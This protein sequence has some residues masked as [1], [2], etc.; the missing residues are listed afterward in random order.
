MKKRIVIASILGLVMMLS[1]LAP[2]VLA[3]PS[4][5]ATVKMGQENGTGSGIRNHDQS[6]HAK[7]KLVPRTVVISAGGSVTYNFTGYHKIAIFA[8]G[9]QPGDVTN[10]DGTIDDS[11]MIDGTPNTDSWTTSAGTFDTPG[12]YLVICNFAPHFVNYDMYGW[13]IVQ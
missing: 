1:A 10:P 2:V 13:V 3:K 5:T 6:G 4:L 9:T 7:Y 11:A 12:R 8:A